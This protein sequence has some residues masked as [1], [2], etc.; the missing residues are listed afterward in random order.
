MYEI[1]TEE[2]GWGIIITMLH[3]NVLNKMYLRGRSGDEKKVRI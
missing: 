2:L 3:N 1:F